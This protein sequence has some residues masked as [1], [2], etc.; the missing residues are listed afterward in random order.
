MKKKLVTVLFLIS[1]LFAASQTMTREQYKAERND[2]LN[3]FMI[4]GFLH[5]I[6]TQYHIVE[7]NREQPSWGNN[8]HDMSPAIVLNA[9]G[10]FFDLMI[11][12]KL[13]DLKLRYK[14]QGG[15]KEKRRIDGMMDTIYYNS[16]IIQ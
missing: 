1:T 10:L 4:S 12:T 3:E 11:V 14:K 15:K 9:S 13:I 8:Q 6:G 16:S 7:N 2:I 5:A